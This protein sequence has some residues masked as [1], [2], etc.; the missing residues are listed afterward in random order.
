MSAETFSNCPALRVSNSN[1]I[2]QRVCC[3]T[4]KDNNMR[5][6]CPIGE[7]TDVQCRIKDGSKLPLGFA[8]RWKERAT[9]I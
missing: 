8:A 5:L 2:P 3:E 1:A 6:F 7:A 4:G 9:L